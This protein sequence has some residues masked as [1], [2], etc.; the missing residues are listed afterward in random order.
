MH[1][2][3][4]GEKRKA[5]RKEALDLA[6]QSRAAMKAAGFLPQAGP[7]A[8]KL[9]EEADRL[10]AE[11]E[12]LKDRGRLEDLSIW[13]MGKVKSTKRGSRSYYYW[14]ATWREGSHTRNVH[15]GSCAKMDAEA[16]LQKARAMKAEA[17]GIKI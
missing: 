12:D 13:T 10:R 3:A 4:S 8:R 16:A 14:M 11:A 7:K 9:Q 17:L 5:L 1:K 6:T 2:T 15:L